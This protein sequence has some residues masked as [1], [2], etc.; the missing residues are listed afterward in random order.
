MDEGSV[1]DDVMQQRALLQVGLSIC[2][3]ELTRVEGKHGVG[4]DALP[5]EEWGKQ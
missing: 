4:S 1:V 5:T 3:Y 2:W